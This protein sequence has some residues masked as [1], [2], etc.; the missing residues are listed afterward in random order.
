MIGILARIELSFVS[1]FSQQFKCIQCN[2]QVAAYQ[3]R[4]R[5]Q[6]YQVC[7]TSEVINYPSL[8]PLREISFKQY[9]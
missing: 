2:Q 4:H 6:Q 9:Q 1:I 8:L 5:P 3:G 7:G